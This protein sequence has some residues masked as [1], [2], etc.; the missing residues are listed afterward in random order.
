RR[1]LLGFGVMSAAGG[2][3]GALLHSMAESII[4]SGVFGILLC[5]AGITG[6]TGMTER[7]RFR[8]WV[9]W[10]AG[11]FSGLLGGLVGNQGGI[12][13]AAMLGFDVR[14]E[15]FVAT[16]TAIALL[17]DGAR[18]P[19]Y[20]ATEGREILSVWPLVALAA[21]G[22]IAGTFLGGRVLRWI[23]EPVF[24]RIV[25]FIILALGVAVLA[26]VARHR[27]ITA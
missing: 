17:V 22:T 26:G 3:T 11:A 5:F 21:A 6:V 14:R 1:L 12:R 24:R 25:A 15:A 16:A 20:L 19:V 13:S 18:M 9:A 2:L 23:P 4:L 10:V 7:M 8:G 27:I